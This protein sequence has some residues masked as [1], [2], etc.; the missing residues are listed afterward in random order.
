MKNAPP[1]PARFLAAALVSDW[2]IRS[3]HT[4]NM[5]RPRATRM[6]T[7]TM[8]TGVYDRAWPMMPPVMAAAV[9][10]LEYMAVMPA[11]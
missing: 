3:S 11:Q 5:L 2:G 8:I 9:P 1:R 6:A 10:R 4:P 7:K